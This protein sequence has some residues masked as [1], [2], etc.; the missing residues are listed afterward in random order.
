MLYWIGANVLSSLNNWATYSKHKFYPMVSVLMLP[1]SPLI[2][3]LE[4][5][6]ILSVCMQKEEKSLILGQP[7]KRMWPD[8]SVYK[9]PVLIVFQGY[10]IYVATQGIA[11]EH[12]E[13]F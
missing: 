11:G 8:T 10:S 4:T 7:Q 5:P 3:R 1:S 12:S 6:M 13:Y 2:C 9:L